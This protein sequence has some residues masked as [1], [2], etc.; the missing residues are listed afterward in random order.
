MIFGSATRGVQIVTMCTMF[1]LC[2]GCGTILPPPVS[3]SPSAS[4]TWTGRLLSVTVKDNTGRTY[5]A[6][7]LD[8]ETGPRT[9]RP[10]IGDSRVRDGE[11]VVMLCPTGVG[12]VPPAE[13][14]IQPGS[15]VSVSG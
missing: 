2:N 8:I 13:L 6:A 11:D 3:A 9:L 5:A 14:G 1:L 7:A 12:I 15:R 4:G 10:A